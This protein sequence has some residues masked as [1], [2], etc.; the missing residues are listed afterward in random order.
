MLHAARARDSMPRSHTSPCAQP[1]P[2]RAA[3]AAMSP[4]MHCTKIQ[5]AHNPLQHAHHSLP[6]HQDP[7]EQPRERG[8]STQHH[9][10]I[11][12]SPLA[13]HHLPHSLLPALHRQTKYKPKYKMQSTQNKRMLADARNDVTKHGIMTRTH[14]TK[15]DYNP[16]NSTHS[17]AAGRAHVERSG[18]CPGR[19]REDGTTFEA[20]LKRQFGPLKVALNNLT[21]D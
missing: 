10:Q 15:E 5:K 19:C 18:V 16:L 12:H 1:G 17:S 13:P 9:L 6:D 14:D 20:N 8:N 3:A 7:P 21:T 2:A 4:S 11:S